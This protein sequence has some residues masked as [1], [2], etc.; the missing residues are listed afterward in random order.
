MNPE[1]RAGPMTQKYPV[2]SQM[3]IT[4]MGM[5]H[6][7]KAFLAPSR[8]WSGNKVYGNVKLNDSFDPVYLRGVLS[9]PRRELPMRKGRSW[10]ASMARST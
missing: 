2:M 7:A 3:E 9:P 1:Y 10:T 4:R 6:V 8:W 5:S